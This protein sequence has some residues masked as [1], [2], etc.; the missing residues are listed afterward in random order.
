MEEEAVENQQRFFPCASPSSTQKIP[1]F[2]YSLLKDISNNFKTPKPHNSRNFQS[3]T[4]QFFTASKQTPFSSS[5]QS[6]LSRPSRPSSAAKSKAALRLKVFKLEQSQSARKE[7]VKKERSLKSLAKS[8][9]VWLNF[10]FENPRLCG[11]GDSTDQQGSKGVVG[12]VGKRESWVRNNAGAG[13]GIDGSWRLPKRQRE[14]SLGDLGGGKGDASCKEVFNAM[15]QVTKSIDEG[16]LKMKS[17]C[18][19]VTDVGMKEKAIKVLMCYNPIWLRIGLYIIFGGE[20]LLPNGDPNTEQEI[21]FLK[22]VIEKQFFSHAGLA[23]TYAYNKLVEGLYRPGYFETLGNVILKRFLLLVLILDRA[24]SQ[25]SLPIKYGIDGL[26]GG[27]PLLFSAQCNTKSSRQMV[28]DFLSSDV[29]HGEGNLLAHLA[30]LGYK[31]NYEQFPLNDYN[32]E[33]VD[34]FQDIQDGMRLCRAI[35]LL[36][37]DSSI[38]MKV[39]LPADTRKKKLLNCG[40]ALKYLKQAGVPLVDDDGSPILEEDIASGEKE[41]IISLLWNMFVH[42]QLPL[43]V[44]KTV[45]SEEIQKICQEPAEFGC[46]ET[47]THLDMLLNWMK[48]ICENYD[49]KMDNFTSLV[50]GKAMWCLLDFYFRAELHCSCA[51]KDLADTSCEESIVSSRDTADAVH[52]F[53]LSQKLTTL[54]GNFPEVLQISDILEYNGACNDRS[55]V[56]LLVFLSSQLLLKRSKDQLNFHKLMG[57]PCQTPERRRSGSERWSTSPE[58]AAKKFKAVQA[59]WQEMAKGNTHSIIK[60]AASA[61]VHSSVRKCSY[62]IKKENAAIIIQSRYRQVIKRQAFLKIKNAVSSLQLYVRAWL[63]VNQTLKHRKLRATVIE[64]IPTETWKQSGSL[65]RHIIFMLDRHNF[66]ELKN[67]ILRIQHAARFWIY[68]RRKRRAILIV[69]EF[70]HKQVNGALEMNSKRGDAAPEGKEKG[71]Y[72]FQLEAAEKTQ[73]A[74]TRL[75]IC[76]SR[77]KPKE[78]AINIQRHFRGWVLRR[79]FLEQKQAIIKVQSVLL[80]L[81]TLRDF[82]GYK[83]A[84]RSAVV[85]QSHARGWR[86]RRAVCQHKHWIVVIQSCWRGW[87]VRRDF[88]S[89]K[90]AAIRIQGV[91]RV[92]IYYKAFHAYRHSAIEIQRYVRGRIARTR[93]LGASCLH[94]VASADSTFLTSRDG[95]L[96]IELKIVLQAIVKLQMWWKRVLVRKSRTEAAIIIQSHTRGWIG[97][98]KAARKKHRIVL[99]Q[100]CWKGYLTR[101]DEKGQLLDLRLRVQKSAIN[102]DDGMRIINTHIAALNELLNMKSLSN[103]LR[104]CTTLDRATGVSQKCC[105]MLVDAGAIDILLKQIRSVSRSIPDQEVLKHVLSILRNLARYPHLTD[106]LIDHCGSVQTILWELLRNK[107]DGYFIA[108][109]L[110]KKICHRQ[111]GIEAM[112]N[113]TPLLKRLHIVIEDLTRKVNQEKRSNRGLAARDST[114]RRLREAVELM[115]LI[116][117]S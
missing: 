80:S 35:Q 1:S 50:D 99:I 40:V 41:L 110:L 71:Q 57:C 42:L 44:T 93:L 2:S 34:L 94:A 13:V 48:V 31:V 3:Q 107:E 104:I 26:D 49:Y 21:A 112:H 102:V 95:Y 113:L 69:D 84:I 79:S 11:C 32:F 18:P 98:R 74:W 6:T 55:V 86:S 63:I 9:T 116:A 106:A 62:E 4:P 89:Q 39:V 101:R 75:S 58:D 36:Q 115:N 65:C 10:L 61:L 47:S 90:E 30:I 45:L 52:N 82:E 20:S 77:C 37:Q 83:V 100:S 16:R 29:M 8:L 23:K 27:S 72:D 53:V 19:M 22:M 85:I 56:I 66:V 70:S 67:S 25:C 92:L 14:G 46:M 114:E 96:S 28:I 17:H 88:L 33:V 7:L 38:L 111:K 81:R 12:R 103:I 117:H 64:D 108:C 78:A 60:P 59:W 97:R 105:E 43:L 87:L 51:Q 15:T 91:V 76:G 68:Q 24:K 73:L 54:L 109:E 5:K